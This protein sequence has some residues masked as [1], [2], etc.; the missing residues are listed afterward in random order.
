[1]NP[2]MIVSIVLLV[3]VG[4]YEFQ[5]WSRRNQ[6]I[7]D[8]EGK[9]KF[10]LYRKNGMEEVYILEA[11]GP[12]VKFPEEAGVAK[13]DKGEYE[14][15][16]EGIFT[17]LWPP[18]ANKFSQLLL[19]CVSFDEGYSLPRRRPTAG[20]AKTEG[21]A[22][23]KQLQF[24]RNM[25]FIDF[26]ARIGNNINDLLEAIRHPKPSMIM[27]ALAII[28]LLAVG[29]CIYFSWSSHNLLAGG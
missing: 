9:M 18:N 3:G 1:M 23:T 27:L 22:L 14:I 4:I 24:A 29:V 28:T 15:K 16:D 12:Y 2:W 6:A 13:P 19:R 10:T 26:A 21:D 25:A 5:A 17:A 20:E 7:K 11:D 8:F